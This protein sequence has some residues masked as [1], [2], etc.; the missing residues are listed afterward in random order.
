MSVNC[1]RGSLA[2]ATMLPPPVEPGAPPPPPPPFGVE[3]SLITTESAAW[4]S[5]SS[6][7]RCCGRR[8]TTPMLMNTVLCLALVSVVAVIGL[9]VTLA[10][11]QPSSCKALSFHCLF[12]SLSP[13]F[14]CLLPCQQLSW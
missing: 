11:A 9:V 3:P 13:V 10:R 1:P 12:K 6:S 7:V 2:L 14:Y 4:L 8:C 5:Q